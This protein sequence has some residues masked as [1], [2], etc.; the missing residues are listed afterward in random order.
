[1]Q[2]RD[3][4]AQ[5]DFALARKLN[6]AENG[7]TAAAEWKIMEGHIAAVREWRKKHKAKP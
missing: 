1:M 7:K 5:K 2:F 4:E 3:D 6:Q